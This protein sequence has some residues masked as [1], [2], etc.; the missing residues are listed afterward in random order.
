MEPLVGLGLSKD[1]RPGVGG[2][3]GVGVPRTPR[4]RKELVVSTKHAGCVIVHT[5]SRNVAA[6]VPGWTFVMGERDW[7]QERAGHWAPPAPPQVAILV[8]GA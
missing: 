5:A 8:G 4:L 1:P 7:K 2:A 6:L 3:P